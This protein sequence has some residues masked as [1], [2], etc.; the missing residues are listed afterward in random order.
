MMSWNT[1]YTGTVEEVSNANEQINTNCG[2]PDTDTETWA[3][4]QQAYQQDFWFIPM[5]PPEGYKNSVG[6]WTQSEMISNVVNVT[7]QEAQSNWWPPSPFPP[8]N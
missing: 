7:E 6:S 8:S 2:F 5:P 3:I 4:P 1:C